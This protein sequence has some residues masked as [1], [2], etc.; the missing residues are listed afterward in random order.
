MS[1]ERSTRF[2]LPAIMEGWLCLAK[3][4]VTFM[5]KRQN[6]L[7]NTQAKCQEPGT[8]EGSPGPESVGIS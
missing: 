8:T 6:T 5:G 4:Q 3:S 2:L 7:E 1:P